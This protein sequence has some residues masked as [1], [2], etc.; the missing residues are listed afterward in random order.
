MQRV[1]DE[2]QIA[3]QHCSRMLDTEDISSSPVGG[4]GGGVDD[5][6]HDDEYG[7]STDQVEIELS[8]GHRRA[9]H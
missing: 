7:S 1:V 4:V 9:R 5:G 8:R 2:Q 3:P 6:E